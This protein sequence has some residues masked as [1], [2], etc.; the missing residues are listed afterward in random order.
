M[1]S[2]AR[3]IHV[4]DQTVCLHRVPFRTV[5]QPELGICQAA[6][7]VHVSDHQL[8]RDLRVGPDGHVHAETNVV[9]IDVRPKLHESRTKQLAEAYRT[10][11]MERPRHPDDDLE[12]ALRLS[13]LIALADE[14]MAEVLKN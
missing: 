6:R 14:L 13:Q 1:R 7:T 5:R 9:E 10:K 12:T 4:D 2:N 8:E 11:R 3:I